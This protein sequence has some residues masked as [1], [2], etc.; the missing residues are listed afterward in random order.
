MFTLCSTR[1]KRLCILFPLLTLLF[2]PVPSFLT[3]AEQSSPTYNVIVD[4]FLGPVYS[5]EPLNLIRTGNGIIFSLNPPV[6]Y[7][8]DAPK[9][10]FYFYPP[11]LDN[12]TITYSKYW[13]LFFGIVVFKNAVI[14]SIDFPPPKIVPGPGE[15]IPV[16]F[17]IWSQFEP[18]VNDS[19]WGFAVQPYDMS[20]YQ[21]GDEIAQLNATS[22]QLLASTGSVDVD[23]LNIHIKI[24]AH[25]ATV[26][27]Y[28]L[29]NDTHGIQP[30]VPYISVG[31][32]REV[33]NFGVPIP[34]TS[35]STGTVVNSPPEVF[36]PNGIN[37]FFALPHVL[38]SSQALAISIS[39]AFPLPT[40]ALYAKFLSRKNIVPFERRKIEDSASSD[41]I[42]KAIKA[43]LK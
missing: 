10:W 7:Y 26:T 30:T 9:S 32:L 13:S 24:L 21:H 3:L 39:V 16:P 2:I 20:S 33:Y 1:S 6:S 42:R 43:H 22:V 12:D 28:L 18:P 41:R 37:N 36:T 34:L 15:S 25:P 8:S 38:P 17:E 31:S 27:M 35:P 14:T 4:H 29:P 23:R 11:P 40:F 19:H 5:A